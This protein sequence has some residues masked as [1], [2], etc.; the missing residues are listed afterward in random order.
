MHDSNRKHVKTRPY[1]LKA[2]AHPLRLFIL[3]KLFKKPHCVCELAEMIGADISTIS[4][5]LSVMK[6]AGLVGDT[7][8]GTTVY[9]SFQCDC[10]MTFISCIENVII[11]NIKR[12]KLSLAKTRT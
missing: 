3:A 6:N 7:K 2:M 11:E 5:H 4:K 1:I 12:D 8:E 9:Y 10:V